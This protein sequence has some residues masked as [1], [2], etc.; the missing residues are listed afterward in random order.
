MLLWTEEKIHRGD[1]EIDNFFLVL[2]RVNKGLTK[3]NKHIFGRLRPSN[4]FF[5]EASWE[6]SSQRSMS[7]PGQL[8]STSHPRKTKKREDV[9]DLSSVTGFLVLF[10]IIDKTISI[11]TC[12]NCCALSTEE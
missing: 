3:G 10:L 4:S 9:V 8:F 11:Q 7:S 5:R 2:G 12:H 1:F 6:E